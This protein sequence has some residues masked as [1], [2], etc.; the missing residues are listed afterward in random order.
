L[1]S[2]VLGGSIALTQHAVLRS[3]VN[4]KLS[5]VIWC[6]FT[7][8]ETSTSWNENA[9]M[10]PGFFF[11]NQNFVMSTFCVRTPAINFHL[12]KPILCSSP[13]LLS[14][15]Q[16]SIQ[17]FIHGFDR[18]PSEIF[19]K[20]NGIYDLIPHFRCVLSHFLPLFRFIHYQCH[21]QV[22]HLRCRY[23]VLWSKRY[24]QNWIHWFW[25]KLVSTQL[26]CNSSLI[27][28]SLRQENW[29]NWPNW[30]AYSYNISLSYKTMLIGATFFFNF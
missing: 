20:F 5:D 27:L 25:I 16:W 13:C 30:V 1:T 12:L 14:L 6:Q 10:A 24:V 11:L 17:E 15:H 28:A 9:W 3:L 22:H 19:F 7:E 23:C 8:L 21:C 26:R 18:R 4:V 2:S 29:P